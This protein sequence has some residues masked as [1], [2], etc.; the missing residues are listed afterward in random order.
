[1]AL[2]R[3]SPHS[4]TSLL[5][6]CPDEDPEFISHVPSSVEDIRSSMDFLASV[7]EL[8]WKRSLPVHGNGVLEPLYSRT[9]M[10]ALIERLAL[11]EKTIRGPHKA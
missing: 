11:W 8:V 5:P 2:L 3:L 7:D 10:N 9:N 1:M 4:I 6:E